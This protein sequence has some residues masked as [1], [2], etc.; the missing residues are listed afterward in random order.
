VDGLQV[1]GDIISKIST[2][3]MIFGYVV[4]LFTCLCYDFII[5]V[6]MIACVLMGNFL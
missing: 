1:V 2:N 5:Y 6:T 4:L 3:C